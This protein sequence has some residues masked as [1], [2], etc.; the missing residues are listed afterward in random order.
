MTQLNTC[1]Q[2]T[3]GDTIDLTLLCFILE[4]S[5]AALHKQQQQHHLYN[6]QTDDLR[7][8]HLISASCSSAGTSGQ[9]QQG[10][11]NGRDQ[12]LAGLA[13]T[14]TSEVSV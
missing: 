3:K 9:Q 12:H 14:A 13:V 7:Q 6:N 8:K 2:F 5:E 1:I 4:S 11:L 10:V